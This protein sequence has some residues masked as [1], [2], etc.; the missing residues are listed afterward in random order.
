MEIG[1]IKN[2]P[3]FPVT[4]HKRLDNKIVYK[5]QDEIRSKRPETEIFS[6]KPIFLIKRV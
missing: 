3:E 4:S 6:L 1:N 2:K 5:I